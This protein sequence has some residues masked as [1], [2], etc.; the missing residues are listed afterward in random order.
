MFCGLQWRRTDVGRKK[1]SL[2][3]CVTRYGEAKAD[4]RS[5]EATVTAS[6]EFYSLWALSLSIDTELF[7]DYLNES[8]VTRAYCSG[9]CEDT[10]LG[11]IGSWKDFER[12]IEGEAGNTHFNE[13]FI[14]EMIDLFDMGARG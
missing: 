6:P 12:E 5:M 10:L 9:D 4:E 3:L 8:A 1:C 13:G 7:S 11:C 2:S 14:H